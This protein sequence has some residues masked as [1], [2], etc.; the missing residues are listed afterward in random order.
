MQDLSK[1]SI[2]ELELEITL[3]K[4]SMVNE[5]VNGIHEAV[6]L[7]Q[8]ESNHQGVGFR[9]DLG[10]SVSIFYDPEHEDWFLA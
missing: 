10:E 6:Q 9:L 5:K 2:Q 4:A 3:R 7:A 8:E 1:Y